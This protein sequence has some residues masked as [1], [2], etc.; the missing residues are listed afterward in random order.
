M[1][2]RLWRVIAAALLL[3]ALVPAPVRGQSAAGREEVVIGT[4]QEPDFLNPLFAGMAAASPV[5]STMFTG[6]VERDDHWKIIP[7]GVAYLPN[8]KDGTWKVSGSRMTVVW[9]IKPRRWQDG[10]PVACADYVF[11]DRIARD[12]RVPVTVREL[13]RRIERI[14]CTKGPGG[15]DITVRWKERYAYANLGITEYGALPQHVIE[16]YYRQNP[17]KLDQAPYGNDPNVTIGDGVYR[18]IEWRKG[19]SITVAAVAN[20]PIFGTPKIKRITWKIIP[21]TNA[22]VVNMLSGNIDAI[23][24]V[25]ISFD[26]AVEIE[27]QSAGRYTVFFAP[28]LTWEHIDFNLD[29][30]LLADVRVRRAIAYAI[31]REQLVQQLFGGKQPVAHAYL[32]PLHP[33]YTDDVQKYS[34][35]PDRARQLLHEAGLTPGPDGILKNPAGT[36]FSIEINTTAGNRVREQVEQI[37]QEYLRAVGIEVKVFNYPA[38]VL[39]GD[40]TAHRK[41]NGMVMYAWVMA[42]TSDCDLLYTADGVPS[43]AN[44]WEGQNYPGYKNPE[45]DR[46]CKTASREIDEAARNRLLQD[47]AK[48]L[49]RDLPALPLYFRVRVGAAKVGL[50]NFNFRA[51]NE[52][53][54]VHRWSWQ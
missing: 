9:K 2:L 23:S 54:N 18:L 33:G 31:N 16:R 37:V 45:M 43:K 6:D 7:Q 46:L 27:R 11:T 20:H 19:A 47:T 13:T 48:I 32:P 14:L 5:L 28:G 42:P 35:D 24:S 29:N 17:G 30:A 34:Y 51:L 50:Q 44:N 38:R 26:E 1:R 3:A 25:G 22:L 21:D 36:R 4:S 12:D 41:F 53:W 52:M 10:R 15:T 8:L 49:A 39:F 40:V